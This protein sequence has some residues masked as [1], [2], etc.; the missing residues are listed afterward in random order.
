LPWR[1]GESKPTKEEVDGA[2]L[3]IAQGT[4]E[5][6]STI[7]RATEDPPSNLR[8][9]ARELRGYAGNVSYTED[10]LLSVR[11]L[12]T[13]GTRSLV[14]SR[15]LEIYVAMLRDV[16]KHTRRGA[17]SFTRD[18]RWVRNVG[19]KSERSLPAGNRR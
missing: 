16:V 19:P 1:G 3:Q 17:P 7:D 10:Y 8:Q 12:G 11:N 13:V 9:L 4:G 18:F 5:Y 6:T 2:Y 14:L 15:S